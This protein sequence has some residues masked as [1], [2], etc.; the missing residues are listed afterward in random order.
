MSTDPQQVPEPEVQP[1]S[2]P[3][4]PQTIPAPTTPEG[5]PG[6]SAPTRAQVAENRASNPN[7]TGPHGLSGDM[8]VSS[9]RTGPASTEGR[10]VGGGLGGIEGTGSKGTAVQRTD[11]EF[12]SRPTEWDAVD[13]SQRDTTPLQ[14]D[15]SRTTHDGGHMGIDRTVGEP[16]PDPIADEK[17]RRD[18]EDVRRTT[19]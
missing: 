9:E 8:G 13:V 5:E 4:G 10:P 3:D 7:S 15:P 17:L 18:P 12:D 1:S 16:L 11:G 2:T 19:T 6:P 14:D